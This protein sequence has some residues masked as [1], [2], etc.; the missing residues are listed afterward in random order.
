M[1]VALGEPAFIGEVGQ[2]ARPGAVGQGF[3]DLETF[4]DSLFHPERFTNES[5]HMHLQ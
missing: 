5:M 1:R 3:D 2:R 4:D